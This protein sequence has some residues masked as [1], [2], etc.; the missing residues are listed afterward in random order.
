M[1]ADI[2]AGRLKY[3]FNI[4]EPDGNPF[5]LNLASYPQHELEMCELLSAY[6]TGHIDFDLK[7][8]NKEGHTLVSMLK[9]Y[10]TNLQYEELL[11]NFPFLKSLDNSIF[12]IE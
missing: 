9:K 8:Q 4:A 3:N 7:F 1:I 2:L 11:D 10:W 5:L 6:E 12:E